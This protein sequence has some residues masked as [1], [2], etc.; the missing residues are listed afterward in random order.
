MSRET[1]R[2]RL[3][4]DLLAQNVAEVIRNLDLSPEDTA[5]ATLAEMYA[6]AIDNGAE[7]QLATF[8]PKLLTVLDQLGASPK[9]RASLRKGGDDG[10][11]TGGLQALRRSR[12]AS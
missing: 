1:G 10:V 5:L 2:F 9:S 12:N 4:D 11:R 3:V 6:E 8:G 7:K